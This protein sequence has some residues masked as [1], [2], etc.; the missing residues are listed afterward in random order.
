M[1]YFASYTQYYSYFEVTYCMNNVEITGD[2]YVGGIIGSYTR[3]STDE[4][5]INTNITLYGEK[6]GH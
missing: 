6:L 5:L 1:D 3:L 4:N 2:T